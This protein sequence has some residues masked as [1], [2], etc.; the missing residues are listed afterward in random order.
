MI[1]EGYYDRTGRTTNPRLA[2]LAG[3]YD[4]CEGEDFTHSDLISL[5]VRLQG[6]RRRGQ[7]PGL[8]EYYA[9]AHAAV[10]KGLD[11]TSDY[12]LV[13]ALVL[14]PHQPDP[15]DPR[16]AAKEP[17]ARRA[18]VGQLLAVRCR[19]IDYQ[20]EC[21][22]LLAGDL[23][24]LG[25]LPHDAR[26]TVEAAQKWYAGSADALLAG[27]DTLDRAICAQLG[28]PTDRRVSPERLRNEL[29][30]PDSGDLFDP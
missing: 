22:L 6:A 30:F 3:L 15:R 19:V 11:L 29:G 23:W 28:W 7:V 24:G 26:A 21:G 5:T 25:G 13:D 16:G 14:G 4:V 9:A 27:L 2:R 20:D 8:K 18:G 12:R 10:G 17:D 1:P